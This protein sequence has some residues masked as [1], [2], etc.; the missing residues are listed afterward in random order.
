ML[1]ILVALALT[2]GSEPATAE[3]DLT[4]ARTWVSLVDAKR[5][6]DS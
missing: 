5:W 4:A 6:N 1:S 2:G 3:A